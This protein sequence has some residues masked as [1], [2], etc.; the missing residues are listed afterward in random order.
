MKRTERTVNV[1]AWGRLG[2]KRVVLYEDRDD[3]DLRMGSTI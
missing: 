2:S 1:K 3:L